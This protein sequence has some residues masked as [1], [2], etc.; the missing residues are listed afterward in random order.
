MRIALID[1]DLVE[2]RFSAPGP[3]KGGCAELVCGQADE[4]DLQWLDRISNQEGFIWRRFIP[5][6]FGAGQR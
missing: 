3:G 4:E 5:E 1:V 6:A 2:A